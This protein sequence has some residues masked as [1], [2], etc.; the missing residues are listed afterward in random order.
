MTRRPSARV[1]LDGG[2]SLSRIIPGVM[3]LLEWNLTPNGL[4][5]WIHAC[6]DLGCTTFDQADIYGS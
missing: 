4:N 3:R 5:R 2:L 6:L 1:V